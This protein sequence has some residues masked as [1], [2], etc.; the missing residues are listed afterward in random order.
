MELTGKVVVVTGGASGIGTGLC[1]R[2]RE[3]G[4][5]ALIIADL[6]GE[7]V[8]ALADELDAVGVTLDVRDEAAIAAM[9][10]EVEAQ[11]GQ[12][13]L[14]CS[15]AGILNLDGGDF[16]ATSS[17]NEV[18]QANWEIHVMAHVYA[19]R[20]CL[21]SMIHRGEGYFLHTISAAGLLSQPYTAAY[22][23]TKH[24]A[25]GFAESLAI[26]HGDDGIKVSCLCPQAVDTA[27][28]GGTDGGSAG[29]DGILSPAQVA[30]AV[31]DGL[32]EESFLILPH[33]QVEQ[34]HLNKAQNYNRW[35]GGMRKLRRSM[36]PPKL[37]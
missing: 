6:N 21:P 28:L 25:I 13:D 16:W 37:S 31:I 18:W 3:E 2:F 35:I 1:R 36:S 7:A 4:V 12:I 33:E 29:I 30:Q 11:F 15:N 32:R 26:S 19:A 27:M 23:T 10:S 8:A 22:A 9:V 20:A 14:F 17:A 5:R 24:A 34:Y